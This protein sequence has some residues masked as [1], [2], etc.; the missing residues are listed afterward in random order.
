MPLPQI[1]F[2]TQIKNVGREER[3]RGGG[4]RQTQRE[5]EGK[6]GKERE[7]EGRGRERRE[8]ER[9]RGIGIGSRWV[10][11]YLKGDPQLW[12]MANLTVGNFMSALPASATVPSSLIPAALSKINNK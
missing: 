5:R 12:W 8:R 11:G 1:T 2:A 3:G 9:G 6:R 10:G 7:R 4:R